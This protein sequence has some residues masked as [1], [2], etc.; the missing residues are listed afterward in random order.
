[1]LPSY[2][3]LNDLTNRCAHL[4]GWRK[5]TSGTKK[6]WTRRQ[7]ARAGARITVG[8]KTNISILR[9]A[10][11]V[12]SFSPSLAGTA[13]SLHRLKRYNRLKKLHGDINFLPLCWTLSHLLLFS[14]P[15]FVNGGLVPCVRLSS[16]PPGPSSAW[17]KHAIHST[18][19]PPPPS[20]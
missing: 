9:R 1:M 8:G 7:R 3:L 16:C 6:R 14:P 20:S 4:S 18:P 17:R 10:D 12:G 5:E 19:P 13:G 15:L 11:D 2:F